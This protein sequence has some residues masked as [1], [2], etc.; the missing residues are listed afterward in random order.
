M[1]EFQPEQQLQVPAAQSDQPK[2]TFTT[3]E[4]LQGI[5]LEDQLLDM[6]HNYRCMSSLL[7]EAC[8]D[9]ET[10]LAQCIEAKKIAL[11]CIL[12]GNRDAVKNWE[13][14]AETQGELKHFIRFFVLQNVEAAWW[15]LGEEE[16]D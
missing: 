11:A 12:R 14:D 5:S 6:A 15:K 3:W 8:T 13:W 2:V 4:D 9:P 1:T 10:F 7:E 16:E